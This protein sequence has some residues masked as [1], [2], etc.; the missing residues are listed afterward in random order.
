MNTETIEIRRVTPDVTDAAA[1]REIRLEALQQNPEAFG[2]TFETEGTQPPDWFSDRLT[3]SIVIGA[4]RGSLLLGIA[5][6]AIQ[7]GQKRAHKGVLWGMYV[8]PAAREAGVGEQLVEAV[9]DLARQHVELIQLTVVR[10]NE[11]A[12]RLYSRLGFV[13]YG[14]EKDALKQ[15]GRYYDEVL[16]AKQLRPR[17]N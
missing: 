4:V 1:Y 5:G 14:L 11:P 6:F 7:Q 10:D 13:E 8:R 17:T 3:N 15:N 16:T 12:Q 9:C 2:S